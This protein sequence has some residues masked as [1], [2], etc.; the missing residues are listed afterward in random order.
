[1]QL[2]EICHVYVISSRVKRSFNDPFSEGMCFNDASIRTRWW[3][4]FATST[5]G[6][7]YK[8]YFH[9]VKHRILSNASNMSRLLL[10][11][12]LIYIV[13][14]S[15]PCN[16]DK[17]VRRID[18]ILPTRR[19]VSDV[20]SHRDYV[21]ILLDRCRLLG[22]TGYSSDRIRR[23]RLQRRIRELI[24]YVVHNFVQNDCKS[25]TFK[26]NF[27]NIAIH[28]FFIYFCILNNII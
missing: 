6:P 27:V 4:N 20:A 14:A 26:C 8:T 11:T 25:L 23:R 9:I 3:N 1:V 5:S 7:R 2:S 19:K 17:K 22:K 16:Q 15:E 10:F 12:L 18:L 28:S 13:L 24:D 21:L